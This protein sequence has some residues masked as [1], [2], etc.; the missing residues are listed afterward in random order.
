MTNAEA[1]IRALVVDYPDATLVELCELFLQK[2]GNW[3]SKTA[4]CRY[5]QILE[6]PRKKKSWYSSQAATSR[7]QK[8][9]LEYWEKIK[10][11]KPENL[12]FID[13]TGIILGATRTHARSQ[14]GT[15]VS[16]LKPFYRGAKVKAIGAISLKEVLGLMTMNNS[17]DG[18]AFDVFTEKILC[19]R[20]WPG[21]VVVM[22]N[23]SAH[24]L[25][26]VVS[27]IEAVGA[28]VIYL[29]P[30]SGSR[31]YEVQ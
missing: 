18:A 4:M 15:R 17:M 14:P 27:K 1:D 16:Q 30:Y 8:L 25:A 9:R 22:D 5:L 10:D 11:I 12:V 2:T 6:L 3:V 21:A 31:C 7:V 24:K 29:S 20:L 28:S 13:E 23:L 26:S 19:P